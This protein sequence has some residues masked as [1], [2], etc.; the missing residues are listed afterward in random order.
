[1]Y[2]EPRVPGSFIV[3]TKFADDDYYWI[4]VVEGASVVGTRVE[5][6]TAW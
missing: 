4:S 2:N 6:A 1:M 5:G 3:K